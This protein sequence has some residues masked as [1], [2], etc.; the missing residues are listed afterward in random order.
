[1][2]NQA[3]YILEVDH[4]L[5]CRMQCRINGVEINKVPKFLMQDPTTLTHS[6]RIAD[7]T[8]AVHPYT[9]P[10]QLEGVVSYFEY[11]LPTS[12]KFEDPEIPHL[13]L[14]AKSPAW[15]PYDK[16]FAQLEE[17]HLDW[18]GHVI[19]VARI[20]GPHG[21]TE[22]GL[23][24]ANAICGE[25][26]HWKLSPVS[27]QYEAADITDNDN[28]GAALKA[29]RQVTLVRTNVLP[30]TYDVCCVH[31]GKRQRAV[32]YVTLAHRWH[33]PLH[34]AKPTV[35][36]TMQRGVR[37]V[38]H[39]TLSRRFRTNDRM[40]CYRRLPCNLFSNTMFCPKV[41]SA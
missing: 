25:E 26:P 13:E 38:L 36:R 41:P 12:A 28:F 3:I 6:I 27:L 9:I 17:S 11:A 35:Q 2:I 40:L 10:L 23:H 30:E 22:V 4:C 1:M 8:N 20:D 39:P 7:P 18:R 15:N 5:L 16:D 21:M 32:D 31:T 14:K 24:P 29:T 19:S 33:I 34:K 37:T